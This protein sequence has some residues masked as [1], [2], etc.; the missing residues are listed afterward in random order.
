M[1]LT[2]SLEGRKH[3]LKGVI[4]SVVRRGPKCIKSV[5]ISGLLGVQFEVQKNA[6]L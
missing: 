3:Q 6:F 5:S 4:E 1:V 2:K